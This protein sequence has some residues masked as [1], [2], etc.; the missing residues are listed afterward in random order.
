MMVIS[1]FGLLICLVLLNNT[2]NCC[3]T[4]I[5]YH[6]HDVKNQSRKQ[7]SSFLQKDLMSVGLLYKMYNAPVFIP[8]AKQ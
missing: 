2:V 7:E 5:L 3:L 6:P 8:S 1:Q 4:I